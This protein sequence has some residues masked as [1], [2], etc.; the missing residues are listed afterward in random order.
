LVYVAIMTRPDISHAVSL[1]SRHLHQPRIMDRVA[2]M[3]IYR[4]LRWSLDY[5]L[6]YSDPNPQMTIH[7]DSDFGGCVETARSQTGLLITMF[8]GAFVWRSVRQ[9][10]VA[11]STAEAEFMAMCDGAKELIYI[12]Q[13]QEELGIKELQQDGPTY[14]EST[15]DKGWDDDT[16]AEAAITQVDM[17]CLL[18]T[19]PHTPVLATLHGDNEG[20]LKMAHEGAD[21]TRTKHM[22][23][24]YHFLKEL[25]ISGWLKVRHVGTNSNMADGL[26]KPLSKFK[27]KVMAQRMGLHPMT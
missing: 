9:P 23:R 5:K 11:L 14:A 12:T 18:T 4:Y 15:M 24:R 27:T 19:A 25:V 7:V 20:A 26:T 16:T 21:N 13:M 1:A 8:G 3:R 22:H 17:V 6:T 10:L 2:C